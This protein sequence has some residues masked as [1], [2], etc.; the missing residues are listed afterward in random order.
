MAAR[1][2]PEGFLWG[3]ATAAYQ[4]EGAVREGGRGESI[5]DRFSHTPG[6]TFR[7]ETGDVACDHYRRWREDVENM[8]DLGVGAYR[9]SVAW[10][11]IFPEGRGRVNR[12][13]MDFYAALVDAALEVG[14]QPVATLYHWDLPQAL[15]DRG[16]W[17]SR[18]TASRF[19]DYAAACFAS[20]GDRVKTWITLNEPWVTAFCGHSTGEHAPGV[21][22]FTAAVQA[23]HVQLL[24]HALAVEAYPQ[25]SPVRGRIGI[26]LN[27]SPVYPITDS[28][29]DEEAAHVA[30][31]YLNRWFL[32]PVF[33]AA[34][35]ADM[36]ALYQRH[37]RAPKTQEH[38]FALLRAHPVDFLGV[39]YYSPKR[40]RRSD[41]QPVLGFEDVVPPDCPKTEMGWE[42]HP[43]SLFHLVTRIARDYGNPAMMITE[44]GAAFR[45]EV[46]VN[47][48]VRDDDRIAYLADHLREARAAIEAGAKL[49]GYF[50]WSLLDNFE[51][52]FGYS[53]RFGITAVDFPTQVR[54]WKK[55]AGWYQQVVATGGAAIDEELRLG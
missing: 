45:D 17:T 13:G 36:L 40:V 39:N 30:D 28:G 5:W 42:I 8:R 11:R 54:T 23:A 10:P 22:D 46:R 29:E 24:A 18:D 52:S 16:G 50:L 15:Q 12:A 51:W 14:I 21:R 1:T 37:G 19:A 43:R 33:R 34:Y 3:A 47:G 48:Q 4:V 25:E 55:S 26:T 6:R 44:N 49:E 27:L 7:G 9:F 41:A 31:G 35:P 2:F 53:R 38:D 20:L 32:D